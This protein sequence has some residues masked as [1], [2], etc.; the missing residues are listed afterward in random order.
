MSGLANFVERSML[1]LTTAS[2]LTFPCE[3]LGSLIVAGNASLISSAHKWE[4]GCIESD[5]GGE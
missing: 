3:A 4:P 1:V 2:D 5:V